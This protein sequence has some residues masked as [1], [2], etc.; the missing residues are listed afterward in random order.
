MQRSARLFL[1]RLLSV[2]LGLFSV[3]TIGYACYLIWCWIRIHTSD[4]YY[5]DY[6]Y[7]TTALVFLGLGFLSLSA[8]LY[9]VWRRS[10]YG[11][12]F[13]VPVFIGLAAM[14]TIPDV[15]PHGY[16]SIADTNY[17]SD[18]TAFFRVWYESQHQ[19]PANESEFKE[20]LRK[21]PE[22]WQYRVGP[23]PTS[24]YKQRG[25]SVPYQIVIVTNA[26]GPRVTD[27]SQRPAVIY[28]CVSGDLQEF[29]VTMTSLQSDVASTAHISHVAGLPD[30]PLELVHAAGRNYPVEQR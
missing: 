1:K 8:G 9:A 24:R 2:F 15:L 25:D 30:E 6:W 10:F 12:L 22:A 21:G 16:S 23:A 14:V 18:V 13:V 28:Y 27:V 4:V 3:P 26:L 17:L 19:F 20:A 5:A 29:W 7:A 11:L